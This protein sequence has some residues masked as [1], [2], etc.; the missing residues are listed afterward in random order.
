MRYELT[1]HEWAGTK[2]MLPNKPRGVPR[3]TWSNGS[4]IGSNSVGGS[5]RAMTNSRLTIWPSSSSPQYGCGFALMSP[6]PS[7]PLQFAVPDRRLE[8][9]SRVPGKID[10]GVLRYFGDERVDH[11]SAHGLGV[12]G[13]EMRL[14]QHLAHYRGGL[15]GIDEIIDD[16]H[17]LAAPAADADDAARHVLE[18]LE[19]A[20]RDVVVARDAHRLDQPDAEFARDDRG[21]HQ[22]AAGYADDR[23]ERAGAGEPPGERARIA[24]E[25]IPR[26]RK[27]L[28]RLRLRLLER[29]RHRSP[30]GQGCGR[31]SAYRARNRTA[32]RAR[33]RPPP[34]ASPA[35]GGTVRR[36]G[37]SARP[38][39]R[40]EW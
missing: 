8:G 26:D 11:G 9:K 32:R 18:H 16:Q 34:F 19:F 2:P 10:P 5:R 20:L 7:A 15:A 37:S 23:L 38:E 24:M 31:S 6:R 39:S 4:S 28:L 30:T 3:A 22:A 40:A 14:G 27:G 36:G 21:G 17:A 35:R 25:L 1:D 12:D 33:R 13:R 29:L